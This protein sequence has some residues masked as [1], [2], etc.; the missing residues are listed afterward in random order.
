[1]RK[2]SEIKGEDALD[3]LANII[4]SFAKIAEDKDFVSVARSGNRLETAKALLK[5]HKAEILFIMATLD[6]QD[7]EDYSPSLAELPKML[8]DLISDPDVALLFHSRDAVTSSGSVTEN[9]E[10]IE[11]EQRNS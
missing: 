1:M 3:V 5:N 10:A 4:E 8:I 2:L 9:T 7:P 11:T 6:G